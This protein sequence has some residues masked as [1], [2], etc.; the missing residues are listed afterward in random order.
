MDVAK[1]TVYITVNLIFRGNVYETFVHSISFPAA[2]PACPGAPAAF[3]ASPVSPN[4]QPQEALQ[5]S[6]AAPVYCKVFAEGYVGGAPVYSSAGG[7]QSGSLP[8]GDWVTFQGTDDSGSWYAVTD[9]NGQWS[10]ID[11]AYLIDCYSN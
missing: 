5:I 10:W 1:I 9:S 3:A 11:P 6:Q 8:N 4:S 2:S 7:E